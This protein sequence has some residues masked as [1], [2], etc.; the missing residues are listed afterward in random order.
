MR[1]I[2]IISLLLFSNI[3]A[4]GCFAI[5]TDV[6]VFTPIYPANIYSIKT[7]KLKE[8]PL[9]FSNGTY[10]GCYKTK[11][12]AINRYKF[13]KRNGFK[14]KNEQIV[15]IKPSSLTRFLIFP[16]FSKTTQKKLSKYKINFLKKLNTLTPEILVKKIPTKFYGNGIEL[17]DIDK[18]SLLPVFN[19]FSFY[20]YYKKHNLSK[21][22]IILYNGVYNLESIRKKFPYLIIKLKANTYIIKAPIYI[23]RNASLVIQNKKVFLETYPKPIFIMYHGKL[24]INNS[25]FITYNTITQKYEKR[26]KIKEEEILFIGKQKPR[27]YFLGLAGSYTLMLDSTFRGLG[28]HDTV[29]TF[30]ISLTQM[31][32]PTFHSSNI[33]DF[34][35]SFRPEGTYVG[36][37]IYNCMMGFYSANAK[38]VYLVGNYMHNNIIY[39]IDPHDYSENLIIA[40]NLLTTA[41]HAHGI[42]IS[43]GVTKTFIAQN[44]SIKNHSN[45]IML[46]RMCPDNILYDNLTMDNG[47][48][49]ISFQESD[50][51]IIEN[52]IISHNIIDGIMIRNSLNTL[53]TNNIVQKNGRNGIEVVTKNIDDTIYRDFPRDPYHKAASCVVKNNIIQNN[54]STQ[55]IVKNNAAIKLLNNKFNKKDINLVGGNLLP[56]ISDILKNN[57]YFKLYGLGNRF[58]P[59]STDLLKIKNSFSDIFINLSFYNKE[60]GIILSNIYK[61][62]KSYILARK[63]IKREASNIIPKALELYGFYNIKTKPQT[64][65]SIIKNISYIIEGA[66]LGNKN[67]EIDIKELKYVFNINKNDIQKAYLQA[68]KRMQQGEIFTPKDKKD[69]I[70]CKLPLFTKKFI[71]SRINIFNYIFNQ[72]RTDNIVDFFEK[73]YQNYSL[74]R[75]IMFKKIEQ[76]YTKKN[77]P[78]IEYTLYIKKRIKLLKTSGPLCK[79]YLQKNIYFKQEVKD[80]IHTDLQKNI[81]K[82]KPLFK[83]YLKLINKHRIKPLSIQT[84]L[85]TLNIKE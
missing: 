37:E 60:S 74:L 66:I 14:F 78:K 83:H 33:L 73:K 27:P 64:K 26:E 85:R 21:K 2:L 12:E 80:I 13:L 23:A 53:I 44:I 1:I 40:R 29:A 52:N 28:F 31:P 22:M 76:I 43:R 19:V 9:K 5:K 17:K 42:V 8:L 16:Y 18:L 39:D 71:I 81:N 49:G 25:H 84:I 72:S 57:F 50:N 7:C 82:Y 24:F 54:F 59:I 46:D 10:I 3:F 70:V 6:G 32:S 41:H 20:R 15:K 58:H 61:T 68:K 35:K 45:G 75:P 47:I 63:E 67:A 36:N 30:G 55:V 77:K 79:R 65:Q 38:N 56:F 69:P 48:M 51:N 11:K 4:K 62:L 34:L